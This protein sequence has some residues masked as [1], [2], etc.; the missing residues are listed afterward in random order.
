MRNIL[1]ALN[2]ILGS[3]FLFL[4]LILIPKTAQGGLSLILI[5]LI[6]FPPI[7]KYAQK[8]RRK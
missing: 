4:G 6:L 7:R 1:I 3:I 2:W 5:S 8:I